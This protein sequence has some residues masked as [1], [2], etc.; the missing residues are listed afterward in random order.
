MAF[1]LKRIVFAWICSLVL[2]CEAFGAEPAIARIRVGIFLPDASQE[3]LLQ[4]NPPI[5]Q[6]LSEYLNEISKY[7]D[8]DYHY[9]TGPLEQLQ[10]A[11]LHNDLDI[12]AGCLRNDEQTSEG[13]LT[14]LHIGSVPLSLFVSPQSSFSQITQEMRVGISKSSGNLADLQAF[15][16]RYNMTTNHVLFPNLA[17]AGSALSRGEIDALV[18]DSGNVTSNSRL[19]T[20]FS[21]KPMTIFTH[22]GNRAF[23]DEIAKA[24]KV[25]SHESPD[26]DQQL[27]KK[28]FGACCSLSEPLTNDELKFLKYGKSYR[29]AL[30]ANDPPYSVFN[31]ETGEFSGILP[32]IIKEI[33]KNNLNLTLT[34][35]AVATK[36]EVS[37]TFFL[38][39]TDMIFTQELLPKGRFYYSDVVFSMPRNLC[40]TQFD[41]NNQNTIIGILKNNLSDNHYVSTSFPNVTVRT[42]STVSECYEAVVKGDIS[43]FLDNQPTIQFMQRKERYKNIDT[44][45]LTPLTESYRLVFTKAEPKELI[46]ILNK[47]I[48]SISQNNINKIISENTLSPRDEKTYLSFLRDHAKFIEPAAILLLI[49]SFLF[50]I[51]RIRSRANT[52]QTALMD[53]LDLGVRTRLALAEKLH[54]LRKQSSSGI[55]IMLKVNDFL[56]VNSAFGSENGIAILKSVCRFLITQSEGGEVFRFGED[57]FVLI[58]Q[59]QNPDWLH[60]FPYQIL[61][62]FEKPIQ[63]PPI[64]YFCAVTMVI[65]TFETANEDIHT[66]AGKLDFTYE[67]ARKRKIQLL[68]YDKDIMHKRSREIEIDMALRNALEN[69][70]LH[71]FFQPIFNTRTNLFDT[72]EFL[73]RLN[74]DRLGDITPDEFI[75]IAEQSGLINQI[76]YFV[77]DK[78]CLWMRHAI[79]QDLSI[80]AINVNVS[81]VQCMQANFTDIVKSILDK[82]N[83]PGK[84]LC[85]E[86]KESVLSDSSIQML[87]VIHKL[88]KIGV[89]F[90]ID[91]FGTKYSSFSLLDKV[92]ANT[93]KI[94]RSFVSQI[95]KRAG[96]RVMIKGITSVAQ[97]L[98][99]YVT[100]EGAE[101]ERQIQFLCECGVNRIQGYFYAKPMSIENADEFFLQE[102]STPY[103]PSDSS[104]D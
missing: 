26:F 34:C 104:V 52:F 55:A 6:Y 63:G 84:V 68:L 28:C 18:S 2:A 67:E 83:L 44:V 10:Q 69:N 93:V 90:A 29:L 8:C 30:P 5:E 33:N 25:I 15:E 13:L 100:A 97:G 32:G 65:V 81:I 72:G 1:Y 64:S 82:H 77:L 21:S 98:G 31:K 59:D 37:N 99:L 87:S 53:D 54:K 62:H 66:L 80:N 49:V 51:F 56:F 20:V 17:A 75:P 43:C 101:S 79:D 61:K 86:I 103:N 9:T 11:L 12:L 88:R 42:F 91:D 57:K 45:F 7:T 14:Y 38:E 16:Q 85:L 78:A 50:Y 48:R 19:L 58:F 74:D 46:S 23:I 24:K 102:G 71:I 41:K 89:R 47:R 60:S 40:G 3:G 39:K 36:K 70:S 94:D 35:M 73:L 4:Q 76:G 95:E 92:P 96:T 22:V 27:T